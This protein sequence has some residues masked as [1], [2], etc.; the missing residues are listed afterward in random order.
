MSIGTTQ[1]KRHRSKKKLWLAVG[2]ESV[3]LLALIIGLIIA[4][5]GNPL[6]GTW[7][8]EDQLTYKFGPRGKGVQVLE[9]DLAR[10]DYKISGKTVTIDFYSEEIPDRTYHFSVEEDTLILDDGTGNEPEQYQRMK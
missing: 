6:E 5:T 8:A 3:V 10:F 9:G 1:K 4:V 7:Y 2:V